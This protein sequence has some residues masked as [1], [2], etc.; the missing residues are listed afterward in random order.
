MDS[1]S[2]R[3]AF[4]RFATGIT[5]VTTRNEEGTA[6]GVTINSFSS[7]SLEPAMVQFNLRKESTLRDF[8]ETHGFFGVNVLNANQSHLSDRFALSDKS[9]KMDDIPLREST[10]GLPIF[11][12]ALAVYECRWK[13]NYDG[14]DHV[15]VLGEVENLHLGSGAPLLYYESR[16]VRLE[17]TE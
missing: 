14:G 11:L 10:F 9:A 3:R 17:Q 16:Y 1:A 15:I 7:L 6:C 4:S 12:D 2:L 5:V 13:K 8:I